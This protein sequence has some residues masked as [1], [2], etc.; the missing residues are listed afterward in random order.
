MTTKS[1]KDVDENAL[2]RA[3]YGKLQYVV[4]TEKRRYALVMKGDNKVDR[5]LVEK[6][7]EYDAMM[8]VVGKMNG[9]MS[10]ADDKDVRNAQLNKPGSG[11]K[12][13]G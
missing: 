9:L 13:N 11:R 3:F 7:C 10:N 5:E 12:P 4:A 1:R 8:K 6:F 2:V